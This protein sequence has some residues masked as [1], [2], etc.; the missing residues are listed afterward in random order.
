M[1]EK[2]TIND[3][4]LA[5]KV[6]GFSPYVSSLDAFGIHLDGKNYEVYAGAL[7]MVYIEG[8]RPMDWFALGESSRYMSMAM[9]TMNAQRNGVTMYLKSGWEEFFFRVGF[10]VDSIESF[11][12]GFERQLARFDS[13]A[14]EF[15]RA[16]DLAAQR[17]SECETKNACDVESE[18]GKRAIYS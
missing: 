6:L 15:G 3:I 8:S 4:G 14:D 9:N 10:Y 16:L 17:F 5:L 1:N 11:R 2:L 18:P 7:P 13:I 12:D